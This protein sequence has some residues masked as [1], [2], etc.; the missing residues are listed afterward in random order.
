MED[1]IRAKV[2]QI[3]KAQDKK[4]FHI[5]IEELPRLLKDDEELEALASAWIA[6]KNWLFC[7]TNKRAFLFCQVITKEFI[8]IPKESL[9]HVA[10]KDGLTQ[11]DIIIKYNN[12]LLIVTMDYKPA[13][14]VYYVLNCL[15]HNKEIDK[16]YH[17]SSF[18]KYLKIAITVL[19][20][21]IIVS[22][23]YG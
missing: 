9:E 11:A 23:L 22:Y 14:H 16:N 3:I 21:F 4:A 15:L 1:K 13:K 10:L 12:E 6:G 2:A 7:V 20:L 8:D 17:V 5:E 18:S 19:V